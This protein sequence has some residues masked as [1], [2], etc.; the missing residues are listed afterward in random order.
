MIQTAE[1]LT[2]TVISSLL[3]M[4]AILVSMSAALA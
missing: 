1:T 3:A 2:R 4:A